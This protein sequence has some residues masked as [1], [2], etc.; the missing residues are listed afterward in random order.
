VARRLTVRRGLR[1][2]H[3]AVRRTVTLGA[4]SGVVLL[5]KTASRRA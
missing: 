1:D 5:D 4:A 3:G 2:L